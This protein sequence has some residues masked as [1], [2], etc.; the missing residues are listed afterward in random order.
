MT[1]LSVAKGKL[2]HGTPSPL[3][4]VRCGNVGSGII[5]FVVLAATCLYLLGVN[6]PHLNI[7]IFAVQH[8]PVRRFSR[9]CGE[10]F[11]RAAAAI[12]L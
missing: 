9:G 5:V 2:G 1:D 4:A 7:F 6:S 11:S 3:N 8:I 12:D 10:A